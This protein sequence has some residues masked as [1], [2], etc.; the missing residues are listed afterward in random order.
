MQIP[1]RVKSQE[2]VVCP[3]RI[4]HSLQFA[5]GLNPAQQWEAIRFVARTYWNSHSPRTLAEFMGSTKGIV[6]QM[7]KALESKWLITRSR[8]EDDGRAVTITVT[9]SG[10][11]LV[12]KD[13]LAQLSLP[14]QRRKS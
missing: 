4:A 14:L 13:P 1:E 8:K 2:L 7:L 9:L 11:A 12:I 6:S 3:C 10:R 5:E